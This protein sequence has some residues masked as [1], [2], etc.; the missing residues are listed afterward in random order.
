MVEPDSPTLDGTM[1]EALLSLALA[2]LNCGEFADARQLLELVHRS[3]HEGCEPQALLLFASWREWRQGDSA[4]R[5]RRLADER[6]EGAS[7]GALAK[8]L[9]AWVLEEAGFVEP[10]LQLLIDLA[11][12]T[13]G[14]PAQALHELLIQRLLRTHGGPSVAQALVA[15]LLDEG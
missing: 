1:V 11:D 14:G 9:H 8:V 7:G 12:R 3:G 15:E 6:P 13:P 5:L 2:G 10:A 4:E